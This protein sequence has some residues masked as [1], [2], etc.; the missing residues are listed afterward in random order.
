MEGGARRGL[1]FDVEVEIHDTTQR[2]KWRAQRNTS[3][4]AQTTRHNGWVCEGEGVI[5]GHESM[6]C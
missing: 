2:K 1:T 5:L 3:N 6:I 4:K